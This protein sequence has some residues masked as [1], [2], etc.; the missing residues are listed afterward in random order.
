MTKQVVEYK[1]I[2]NIQLKPLYLVCHVFL[3][4]K[5]NKDTSSLFLKKK[6]GHT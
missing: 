1:V 3:L 4:L 6:L 2:E 5:L